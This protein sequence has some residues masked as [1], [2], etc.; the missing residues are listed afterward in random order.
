MSMERHDRASTD[1][2]VIDAWVRSTAW[3]WYNP[4]KAWSGASYQHNYQMAPIVHY[5]VTLGSAC[6]PPT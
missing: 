5:I 1:M 2:G 6:A 3:V 4:A